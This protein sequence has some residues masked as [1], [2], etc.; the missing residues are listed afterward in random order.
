MPRCWRAGWATPAKTS[1]PAAGRTSGARGRR[2]GA[3][4]PAA[5]HLQ[6][7]DLLHH[8]QFPRRRTQSCSARER[9]PLRSTAFWGDVDHQLRGSPYVFRTTCPRSTVAAEASAANRAVRATS[10]SSA[11]ASES[12]SPLLNQEHPLRHRRSARA[13]HKRLRRSRH[14]HRLGLQRGEPEALVPQR[15]K[16]RGTRAAR[17]ASRTDGGLQPAEQPRLGSSSR[18]RR[19]RDSGR[20]R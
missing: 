20:R 1:S 16:D 6:S 18:S 11:P 8:T 9:Q 4:R 14:S 19:R 17:M 3:H 7:R 12:A 15:G 13:Q 5:R 2:S 10:R